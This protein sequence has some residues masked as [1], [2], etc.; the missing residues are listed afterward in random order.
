MVPPIGRAAASAQP[1]PLRLPVTADVTGQRQVGR[2]LPP[3]TD[4]HQRHSPPYLL[5]RPIL[6]IEVQE[7][8]PTVV[9][10]LHRPPPS[11]LTQEQIVPGHA[12]RDAIPPMLPRA[13]P[14][15]A[16]LDF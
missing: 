5:Q 6:I 1:G 10:V 7:D 3:C 4:L 12:T 11:I 15:E 2:Q 8:L 16:K 14:T 9:A 13:H